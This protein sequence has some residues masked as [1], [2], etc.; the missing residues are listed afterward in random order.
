MKEGYLRLVR[1]LVLLM[2]IAWALLNVLLGRTLNQFQV[3]K[4]LLIQLSVQ[5]ISVMIQ[6]IGRESICLKRSYAVPRRRVVLVKV[7][8]PLMNTVGV[9]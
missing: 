2:L 7:H 1:V 9:T 5:V 8:A 3:L 4:E 6:L